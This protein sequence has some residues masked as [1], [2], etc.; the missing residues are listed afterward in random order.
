MS[1][2]GKAKHSN[3][4]EENT[5]TQTHTSS[6]EALVCFIT[7]CYSNSM[8]SLSFSYPFF[9]IPLH[10]SLNLPPSIYPIIPAYSPQTYS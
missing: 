6:V 1:D 4:L 5:F 7:S 10:T 9:S 2:Q 8:I 3:I